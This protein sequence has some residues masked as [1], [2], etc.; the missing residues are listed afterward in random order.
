MRYRIRPTQPPVALQLPDQGDGYRHLHPYPKAESYQQA[1]D[2]RRLP[3]I[4][5]VKDMTKA[6]ALRQAQ[7][8]LLRGG[9]QPTAS[10]KNENRAQV[11]GQTPGAN[12]AQ[13]RFT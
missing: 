7:L 6:E 11:V 5:A 8:L 4:R 10:N 1:L 9:L 2:I 12:S 13:P 3:S